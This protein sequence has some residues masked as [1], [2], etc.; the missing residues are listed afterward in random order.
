M[1]MDI[2]IDEFSESA[3]NP[4]SM[5]YQVPDHHNLHKQGT[6]FKFCFFRENFHC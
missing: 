6:V 4:V 3:G 5:G 2:F 1:L